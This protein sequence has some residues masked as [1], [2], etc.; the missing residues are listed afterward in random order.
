MSEKSHHVAWADRIGL[1]KLWAKDIEAMRFAFGTDDYS[2]AV[3]GFYYDIVNVKNGPQLK[4]IIDIHIKTKW[5]PEIESR[6]N[7]WE[8][9]HPYEAMDKNNVEFERRSVERELLP[10]LG[11]FMKQ[12]LEDNGFGFYESVYEEED[13]MI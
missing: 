3:W 7:Q 5:K 2:T 12:L 9:D 1:N 13:E 11:Y 10:E 4:D 6:V 8:G